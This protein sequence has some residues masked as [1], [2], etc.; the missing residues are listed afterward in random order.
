MPDIGA[1]PKDHIVQSHPEAGLD[2][3]ADWDLVL[4][5]THHRM[6]NTLNLLGASARRDLTRPRSS[7]LSE[8]IDR[9]EGRLV[10]FG[11]V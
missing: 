1:R 4:R 6:K 3:P 11:L 8:A 5:E 10:A 9:Y 2:D 7:D